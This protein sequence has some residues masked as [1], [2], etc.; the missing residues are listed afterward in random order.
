MLRKLATEGNS[1]EMVGNVLLK[2]KM[3]E[4][5]EQNLKNL[6]VFKLE[7]LRRTYAFL[8]AISDDDERVIK[9]KHLGIRKMIWHQLTKL[10]PQVCLP[11]RGT[12]YS[13]RPGEEA[14]VVCR[15]CKKGACPS[16][17][18]QGEEQGLEAREVLMKYKYLCDECDEE[19]EKHTGI[20]RLEPEDF[21]K[22]KAKKKAPTETANLTEDDPEE[23][24]KEDD[25]DNPPPQDQIEEINLEDDETFAAAQSQAQGKKLDKQT[26]NKGKP[27]KKDDPTDKSKITCPHLMKG[28]C[29]FGISGRKHHDAKTQCPFKHPRVCDRLLRHGDKGAQGCKESR[30]TCN[31]LHPK[32]CPNSMEGVCLVVGCKQGLHVNGSNTKEVRERHEKR[33]GGGMRGE[34]KRRGGWRREETR[35][36]D[37]ALP[38]PGLPTALPMVLGQ[39]A[40]AAAAAPTPTTT[41]PFLGAQ[42]VATLV[43]QEIIAALKELKEAAAPPPPAKEKVVWDVLRG[44]KEEMRSILRE[45]GF[46]NF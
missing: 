35:Y 17:Y 7:D 24:E 22:E 14:N 13:L 26:T 31:K 10:M 20:N 28:R 16:C 40:A 44:N 18:P 41:T 2:V 9:L 27:D 30:N 37:P 11:C 39:Q 33:R 38:A 4:N 3:Q 19:V 12:I 29:F 32:I 45:L 1:Q 34:E 23:E 21:R 42:D 36:P 6:G 5:Y 8:L 15:R 46:L 25:D 43:R